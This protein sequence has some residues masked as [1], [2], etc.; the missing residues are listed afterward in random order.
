MRL[1]SPVFAIKWADATF[2]VHAAG[3]GNVVGSVVAAVLTFHMDIFR[4]ETRLP[5][6]SQRPSRLWCSASTSTLEVGW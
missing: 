4:C 2:G 1:S 6:Y 3:T 5:P